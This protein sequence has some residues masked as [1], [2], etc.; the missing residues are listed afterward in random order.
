MIL[1]MLETIATNEELFVAAMLG[2]RGLHWDFTTEG[3]DSGATKF[4]PDYTDF[5]K[6][7][8]EVGVREMSESP[9]CPVWVPE[10]YRKYLDPQAVEYASQNPGYFDMIGNGVTFAS[11]IE[12]GAD[13]DNY[14]KETF[15]NIIT[16]KQPIE[17]FDEY[18]KT[19]Y[20]NGGQ[21][22]TE[23][24]QRMYDEYFK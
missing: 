6:R 20:A 3:A 24:A 11:Q 19:R 15:M 23:E 22:M 10:I 2:E 4:L 1:D 8:G 13:L 9:Y 14:T 17:S 16:G 5:N 12:Y 7:L 18:V 21:A